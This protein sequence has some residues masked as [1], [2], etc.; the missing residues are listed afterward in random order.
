MQKMGLVH[1]QMALAVTFFFLGAWQLGGR[2]DLDGAPYMLAG[3]CW[4][5]FAVYMGRTNRRGS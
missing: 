1:V 5:A 4:V 2:H 3:V